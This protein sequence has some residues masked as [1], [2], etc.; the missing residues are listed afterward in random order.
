LIAWVNL[1]RWTATAIW[2]QKDERQ[3][4]VK[5][6]QNPPWRHHYI[7]EFYLR[8]WTSEKGQL[9]QFSKPYLDKVVAKRVYPR[10]TGFQDRL[11][12][13]EGLPEAER[14]QLE[15]HFYSPVDSAAASVLHALKVGRRELAQKERIAWARFIT[16]LIL[17][18][19]ENIK[20]AI[21]KLSRTILEVAHA[22]EKRYRRVRKLGDPPTFK[23]LMASLDLS[24]DLTRSAKSAVASVA[25]DSLVVRSLVNMTWGVISMPFDVPALLTSDRPC[26]ILNGMN[27]PECQ[28]LLPLTPKLVFYAVHSK[29]KAFEMSLVPN[30]Q[31]FEQINDVVVSQAIKFVYGTSEAP[32]QYV[33]QNMGTAPAAPVAGRMVSKKQ[34]KREKRELNQSISRVG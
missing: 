34:R 20:A 13:L 14:H 22:E 24:A 19:P 6:G 16:S 25:N 32:L 30:R 21:A 17:R 2:K 5:E 7:P 26:S 31:V 23:D 33:Q 3:I 12:D 8:Q 4:S 18:N 28:V 10:Q 29:E 27:H 15:T 1:D 11:N 9:T